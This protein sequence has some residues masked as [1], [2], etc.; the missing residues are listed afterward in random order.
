MSSGLNSTG[1]K[2]GSSPVPAGRLRPLVLVV[3][4]EIGIAELL[5][6]NL[7]HEGFDVVHAAT[8]EAAAR[9]VDAALPALVLLDWM[10]PGQSGVDLLRRWRQQ[11]HTRELPVIMLT[12]RVEEG[13]RVQGLDLGADDYVAKP[14]S[15]RELMARIRSV[16]R[17]K[18]PDQAPQALVVGGVVLRPASR[19]TL[20]A[21]RPLRLGPIEFR[22]L[23]VLMAHPE[24]VYSRAQLLDK[25]WGDHVEVEDRTVDAQV[26]RLRDALE[27]AGA[28]ACVQTVRGMGYRFDAAAAANLPGG[29]A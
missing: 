28:Q 10:L 20:V 22:L 11:A 5:A 4:D 15:T 19:E 14:F 3:E 27:T 7:R 26:K 2:P 23:Q 21:G 8:A 9:A 18:A 1:L 24:R 16:L 25:V 17:R 12:A 13:D 29:A 6:V